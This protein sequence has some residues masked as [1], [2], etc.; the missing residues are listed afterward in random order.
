MTRMT[1]GT[2]AGRPGTPDEGAAA[3][4][5]LASDEAAYVHGALIPVD[6]GVTAT[7]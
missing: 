5:W 6:G 1:A 7:R 3:I 4:A 2:P